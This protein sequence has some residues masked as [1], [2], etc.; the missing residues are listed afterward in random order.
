M[1]LK[2][3]AAFTVLGYVFLHRPPLFCKVSVDAIISMTKVLG[4]KQAREIAEYK[5]LLELTGG[6]RLRDTDLVSSKV[7]SIG[8][9]RL[10]MLK[11]SGEY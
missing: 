2:V 8:A 9:K 1:Y 3:C 7:C 11:E 4:G 10:K 5:R 6:V